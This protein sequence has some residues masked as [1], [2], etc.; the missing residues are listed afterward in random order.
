MILGGFSVGGVLDALVA[1]AGGLVALLLGGKGETRFVVTVPPDTPA[2]AVVHVAGDFQGWQPGANAWRLERRRDGRYEI[3]LPDLP[4]ADLQFKFTRGSWATVEKGGR[5]EEIANRTVTLRPGKKYE[6]TVAAWADGGLEP[7]ARESTVVGE[8]QLRSFPGFANGRTVRVWLPPDYATSGRRYPVLY[9]WDGQNLFDD[10]TSFVGEW[11]ID[12]T[13]TRIAEEDPAR[14]WIV[15][16]LDNG[17]GDRRDEYTPWPFGPRGGGGG[18]RHL[19]E[20]VQTLIPKIDAEYRTRATREGRAIGGSSLGGLM[21]LYAT[22]ER[23]DVFGAG[24][25]FSPSLQWGEP[26]ALPWFARKGRP[27]NVRLYVDMGALETGRLSDQD[28]NGVSDALDQLRRFRDEV[29]RLDT[30][31]TRDTRLVEDPAGK[32]HESAWSRRFPA[33]FTWMAAERP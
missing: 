30:D 22:F 19:R 27:E 28:D 2:D 3:V 16:G 8:M 33:A 15:V 11:K 6:F 10:A 4:R 32:H 31:E 26:S 5:G 18:V 25:A 20:L 23:P 12:E 1:I 17:G 24:L 14:A 9:L 29:L 21:T 13:M 7:P